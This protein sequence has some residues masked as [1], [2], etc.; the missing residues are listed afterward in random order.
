MEEKRKQSEICF[1]YPDG[2]VSDYELHEQ[3]LEGVDDTELR[4]A[5]RDRMLE[6]FRNQ[7]KEWERDPIAWEEKMKRQYINEAGLDEEQANNLIR[8]QA[9]IFR[10]P[11]ALEAQADRVFGLDKQEGD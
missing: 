11:G 3:I 9:E 4:R 6:V 1:V 10:T 5:S 8:R 7:Q 2:T